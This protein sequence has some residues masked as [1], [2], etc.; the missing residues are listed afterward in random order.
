MTRLV[1]PFELFLF[2][3]QISDVLGVRDAS[4]FLV[5]AWEKREFFKDDDIQGMDQ[6]TRYLYPDFLNDLGINFGNAGLHKF[7]LE[8]WQ[9]L[10]SFPGYENASWNIP[11]A[12][13]S[14]GLIEEALEALEDASGVCLRKNTIRANLLRNKDK[15]MAFAFYLRALD[16]DDPFDAH[17]E[18]LDL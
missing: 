11:V 17:T 15:S 5:K 14:L 12:L 4:V 18:W 9:E 3:Q 2:Y 13:N 6:T 7:S 16:E 1:D 8:C 10:Q